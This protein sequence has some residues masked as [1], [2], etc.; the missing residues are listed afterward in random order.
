MA[1][2][3]EVL[4]RSKFSFSEANIDSLLAAI[5]LRG[6]RIEPEASSIEIPDEGDRPFLEVSRATGALIVTG[7]T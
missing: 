2:Y 5:V 7:N 6:T 3:R 4:V 1:E